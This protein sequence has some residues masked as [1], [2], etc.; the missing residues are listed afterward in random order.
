[1]QKLTVEVWS[2]IACPWCYVG[3]R[4]LQAALRDFP[5]RDQVEVVWRSFELDPSA[6]REALPP[7]AH[8]ERL[9]RKYGRTLAQA[10]QLLEQMTRL[11]ASEGL[12]FD[13][14]RIRT[15][16]SFDAH[17]MLHLAKELGRQD[18]LKERL[19]AAYFCE[20]QVISDADTL[21]RL[22]SEVGLDVDRAQAL[23][24][25][26][27]YA[28]EVRAEEREAQQLGIQGVPFF[29]LGRRYGVSGAQS[30][31]V[32]RE[33]LER[34]HRELPAITELGADGGV[35]GPDGCS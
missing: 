20:G 1:M 24:S 32:M 3:K 17:R 30:R 11:A 21:V 26:D 10:Q 7:S 33:A 14:G 8:A 31:E 28:A 22:A 5:S 23:V 35:C 12:A 2:D 25:T 9:A 6:P 19:L 18:A 34:A 29:L 15:A 4:R 27:L 16:S 13:Y